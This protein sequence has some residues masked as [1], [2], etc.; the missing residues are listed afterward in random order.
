MLTKVG[1]S[2]VAIP[3]I[4]FGATA[5]ADMPDTYG[6]SV[7]EERALAT[8]RAILDHPHGFIDTSR[9]YG[10]GRSEALI[11]KV[12]RERGWPAGRIL[13]T[14]LDRDMDSLRFDGAR[15]RRSL[16]E[17]LAA[18]GVDSVDLLHL[19]DP[20]YASDLSDVTGRGGALD[21]LMRMK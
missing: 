6:Y 20:E 16:E 15:A 11:G 4:G 18:L 1:K 12:V 9:N 7:G 13:S 10:L 14:K 19:H 17:S 21:A 3:R 2:D 5:L 8:I